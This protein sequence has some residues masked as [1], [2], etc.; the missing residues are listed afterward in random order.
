ML[1]NYLAHHWARGVE[2]F[3]F[4][5][6]RL[7]T[8]SVWKRQHNATPDANHIFNRSCVPQVDIGLVTQAL[9]KHRKFEGAARR[10]GEGAPGVNLV[11]T[12]DGYVSCL[13]ANCAAW[14]PAHPLPEP[15]DAEHDYPRG[16]PG[17]GR[18]AGLGQAP[19]EHARPG[20]PSLGL[21]ASGPTGDRTGGAHPGSRNAAGSDD[22]GR[23]PEWVA[24]ARTRTATPVYRMASLL[25]F[26]SVIVLVPYVAIVLGIDALREDV[27]SLAQVRRSTPGHGEGTGVRPDRDA[28]V[29]P[30]AKDDGGSRMQVSVLREDDG[31][32][33]L[34]YAATR[35]ESCR[36]L[37]RLGRPACPAGNDLPARAGRAG[38]LP[39]LLRGN[40][41]GIPLAGERPINTG[42]EWTWRA[43]VQRL[44]E[45]AG[46]DSVFAR[47]VSPVSPVSPVAMSLDTERQPACRSIGGGPPP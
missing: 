6:A 36:A 28:D 34:G 13:S 26:S 38:G 46:T 5:A 20:G 25:A 3:A 33:L 18:A 4:L 9:W 15:D 43:E 44:D 23:N 41:R 42:R 7:R 11:P 47:V 1:R 35:D 2:D 27:R 17:T 24:V 32:V 10:L 29:D 8:G 31:T 21:T 39:M 16:A 40:D 30:G 19:A 22:I 37:D 45:V 14:R 12:V